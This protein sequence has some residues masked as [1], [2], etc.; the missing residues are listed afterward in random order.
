MK[1]LRGYLIIAGAIL[2][3]GILIAH[4]PVQSLTPHYEFMPRDDGFFLFDSTTGQVWLLNLTKPEWTRL[5][6]PKPQ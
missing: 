2:L 6:L 1:E 5:P 3:A 4:R